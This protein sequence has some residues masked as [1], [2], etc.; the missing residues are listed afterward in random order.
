M[1]RAFRLRE[2]ARP[3]GTMDGE[4]ATAISELFTDE[5]RANV[6]RNL[7]ELASDGKDSS[8]VTAAKLAVDLID[9]Y[10]PPDVEM[11][12]DFE[13]LSVAELWEIASSLD[14]NLQGEGTNDR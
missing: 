5:A 8:A 2:T 4:G 9:R 14:T 12:T 3:I 10:N 11:V 6:V 7:I 1:G 13:L